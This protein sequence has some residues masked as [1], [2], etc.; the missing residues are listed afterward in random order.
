[1]PLTEMQKQR[2]GLIDDYRYYYQMIE[3]AKWKERYNAYIVHSVKE[4]PS[5]GFNCPGLGPTA[6]HFL[7]KQQ[8]FQHELDAW[9][10]ALFSTYKKVQMVDEAIIWKRAQMQA[11][12]RPWL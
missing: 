11:V 8:N 5:R 10:R 12:H 7:G 6:N 4:L 9:N 1:L 2:Q 3:K